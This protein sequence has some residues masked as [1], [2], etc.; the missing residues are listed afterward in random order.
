MKRIL[1]IEDD[2]ALAE[3]LSILGTSKPPA[4]LGSQIKALAIQK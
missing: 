4:R 1:I 3:E 2:E